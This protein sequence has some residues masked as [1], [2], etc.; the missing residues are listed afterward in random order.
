MTQV[1]TVLTLRELWRAPSRLPDGGTSMRKAF[2]KSA[3]DRLL[4]MREQVLADIANDAA[5]TREGQKD[6]GM[7]AYD[8]ASEERDRDISMIL[9]DRD[10]QKLQAI[11]DALERI[12][13]GTYGIC[14]ACELDIAEERLKALPFTRLCVTCQADQER[15]AKQTRR[16]EDERGYR[17]FAVGDADEENG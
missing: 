3:R 4:G 15:E 17:R 14:E 11:D 8:L 1:R 5:V 12:K 6:E 10:R 7:D 9:S 2:L 16:P 13:A